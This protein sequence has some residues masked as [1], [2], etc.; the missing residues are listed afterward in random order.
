MVKNKFSIARQE[1]A[2]YISVMSVYWLPGYAWSQGISSN[3]TD[4]I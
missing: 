3:G 2:E 4:L 1:Y